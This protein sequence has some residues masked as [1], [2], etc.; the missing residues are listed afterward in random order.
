[1]PAT[2]VQAAR[3]NAVRTGATPQARRARSTRAARAR[4]AAA[5]TWETWPDWAAPADAGSARRGTPSVGNVA[6]LGSASGVGGPHRRA[7]GAGRLPLRDEPDPPE[8]PPRAPS[9]RTSSRGPPRMAPRP[10]GGVR[11][12]TPSGGEVLLTRRHFLYGA[13]GIG[14]LAAAGRRGNRDPRSRWE[15]RRTT[16]SPCSKCPKS[17]VTAVIASDAFAEV[18]FAEAHAAGQHLRAALRPRSCGRN[19]DEIAACLL[20]GETG[21]PLTQVALLSLS[22][23]QLRHRARAGRGVGRGPSRCTTCAPP[24]RA[25]SG[26]KPT[27]STACGAST[28]ARSDGSSLGTPTLVDEGDA[29]WETPAIAAVGNRAFWQV[30]PKAD[31]AKAQPRTRCSNAPPWGRRTSRWRGRRTG[32][33]HRPPYGLERFARHHA[34]QPTPVP[35]TTSSPTSTR[36]RAKRSTTLVLPSSMKPLEAGYGA[37]GLHVRVRWRVP[38]TATASPTSA[39][40][41]PPPP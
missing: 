22:V 21:K 24:R 7:S 6:G 33:W 13:L 41:C 30:L 29:D 12:P 35:S 5:V 32:A 34:A 14:A 15:A 11:V 39:R 28:T 27:S 20:P 8:P 18:D 40:T 23:G 26:P 37:T 25:L 31:G 10:H 2:R 4:T 17:A 36:P 9:A 16:T 1:M 38:S 3:P 19:D